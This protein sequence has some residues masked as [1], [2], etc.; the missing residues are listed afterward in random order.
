M[1][2]A[3]DKHYQKLG[4][5]VVAVAI[6]ATKGYHMVLRAPVGPS[7]DL[8]GRKIRGTPSYHTVIGMLG[9]S[10]VVLPG[11]EV[12]SALE[13]GVVDGAA[14]PASGVLGMRWYEVAKYML[15][16]SFGLS[17][18]LFLMNLNAWN[19]LTDAE[20]NI[21]LAEGRKAEDTWFKEYDRMVDGGRGRTDQA[22][23]AGHRDGRDAEHQGSGGVGARAMGPGREEERPGGQ[24]PARAAQAPGT[25][26]LERGGRRTGRPAMH[27][28]WRKLADLHDAITSA[29]FAGAAAVLGAIAFSFCY[30]VTARYFFAAPTSWA[31]A[32]VSYLL[33][34]AI[35]LAV[36]ELTRRRAHV[37]INLLLDRLSPRSA[38]L[39]NRMIRAS[40]AA[41][42]LLA[43]WISGN[44]TLDQFSLGIDTISTYP[45]PK[46]W[47]SIFIPYGM[48][49]SG[50]YFLRDLAE[51]RCGRRYR[52]DVDAMTWWVALSGGIGLLLGLLFLGIPVFVAFLILN[53]AGMLVLIGTGRLRHV[54]QQHLHHRDHDRA[55]DRAAVHP[56]GR[57]PVPL[58]R[59]GGGVRFA[60]PA[61]RPDSRPAIRAVHPA[62]GDPRRAVGRRHGGGRPARALAVPRDASGAATTRG[63]RPARSSAAPASTRSFRRACSP[64]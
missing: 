3:L 36:P 16:P 59:D 53:V 43:T 54:R 19:R 21:L 37:A 55:R 49:S 7:G 51:R 9:A 48:L 1:V 2:E 5:K 39:L 10:P 17:H 46:W 47:V 27:P 32:F 56:H 4:L 6:S 24:G 22:R 15:R 35:F 13:K 23:H 26:R 28:F 18:Y 60:R 61:G 64:S 45:I 25:D 31:N 52:D 33:C 58:R 42:C 12:Y 29:S 8:Q 34:A 50:L 41:A 30:E 57:D 11:G 38:L 20:R 40:G 62:F 63:C 14:W 44:A